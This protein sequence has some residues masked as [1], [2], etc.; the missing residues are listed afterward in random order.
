ME[1]DISFLHEIINGIRQCGHFLHFKMGG[2]AGRRRILFTLLKN[3][4]L[5]QRELQDMLGVKSGSLSEM[6]I[7]MEM[8]G[9][10]EKVRSKKDG[11]QLV[12]KL[13]DAGVVQAELSQ[14]EYERKVVKMMSCFTWDQQYQLHE[15]LK[16]MT[17]HWKELEEDEDFNFP[18][19]EDKNQ[20][21]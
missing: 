21:R 11:R 7:K 18:L 19:L 14:K 17:I 9:L 1:Q 3:K 5:L 20:N 12:L 4:E 6:I 16:T 13:T 8:D 10:I 15:L 2:K